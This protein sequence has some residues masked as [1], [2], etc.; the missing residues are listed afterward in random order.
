MTSLARPGNLPGRAKPGTQALEPIACSPV[1]GSSVL[2]PSRPTLPSP[3][4]SERPEAA[5]GSPRGAR[6]ARRLSPCGRSEREPGRRSHPRPSQ[7]LA[8]PCECPFI[9]TDSLHA[10]GVVKE[11]DAIA[12]DGKRAQRMPAGGIVD[13]PEYSTIQAQGPVTTLDRVRAGGHDP[14]GWSDWVPHPGP[15]PRGRWRR[16]PAR[17]GVLGSDL[18]ACRCRREL[19][20]ALAG[21]ELHR[22]RVSAPR[23][24]TTWLSPVRQGLEA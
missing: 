1:C 11:L 20:P 15:T 7:G 3:V 17:R 16:W 21:V 8:V 14:H 9:T 4:T 18:P 24:R 10:V 19:W 5:T 23:A 6:S 12:R 13:D 22:D 2:P